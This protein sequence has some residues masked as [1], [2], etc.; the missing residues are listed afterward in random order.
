[1]LPLS[2]KKIAAPKPK[3]SS[4][5]KEKI[6]FHRLDLALGIVAAI[7]NAEALSSAAVASSACTDQA[8][9]ARTSTAINTYAL[10][11]NS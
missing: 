4:T 9:A 1:M 8:S 2:S 7:T 10:A 5:G 6:F 11:L 3:A